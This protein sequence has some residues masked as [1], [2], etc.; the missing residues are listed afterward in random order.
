MDISAPSYF[1][2]HKGTMLTHS[3]LVALAT[4]LLAL[5]SLSLS[6][7]AHH[8]TPLWFP[9]AAAI[10]VLYR[11]PPRHWGLPLLASGLGIVLASFALIGISILPVKL[12]AINLLEAAVCAQLLRRSLPASDPLSDLSSWL[13]FVVCAVI[14]TPLF[15]ALLA[16]VA[17]PA[18]DQPFWQP[19]GTWFISEAIGVLSLAPLGLSYRRRT[20]AT[21]NLY[22]LLLTLMLTL[23]FSYLA[24]I[25]LPFPFTFVILPLLWAAIALPRFE[26]FTVCFC[27]ILLITVM[28]SLGLAHFQTANSRLGDLGLYLPMLLILVPAHAMAM[29]MHTFRVEKQH[30]VESESR[31]RSALEYSAIGMALVS[32]EGKWLQVNQA[33]CKLL[34]YTPERL[35]RLTFQAITHPDDLNADLSQ[36]HDLLD[37][38]ISSYTME[39]RYI[40]SDGQTVWALL[41]VSLVRDAEGQPLYFI[42]QVED[43]SGLKRSE[44]ENNRLVERITLANQVGGVG[45]WEWV[46]NQENF[47]WDQRMFELYD[48]SPDQAPTLA[49][50]RTLLVPEDRDRTDR[51]LAEILAQPRPFVMEFRIITRSGKL[52]HIRGQGNVILDDQGRPLRLIGTNIDMTELKSLAEALHEEKERLHITL[53]AIGEGVISTDS[54]QRIT[55]MNPVAE[56]MCGWPLDLAIGMPVAGVVR[57][58][59]GKDGPEIENLTQYPRQWPADYALVLHSRD[60]RYFDV[61][62]SV[63]PLKT[64]DGETMG[65]VMVLQDVTASREL[66]KKLSYSASHDALTGL[67]N[68]T[69]FEK[70]LKAAIVAGGEPSPHSLVFLDLDR[71]KAVNDTAGH[72]AGDAL[73]RD[74][75]QLMRHQ[76]RGSD[77]LARL[78]GDEFGLILFD[79]RL[80]QAKSLMQQ[81]VNQISQHPFYWEG[82]IYRVGASAG[83]TRIDGDAKSSE[84]LAQADIACYTAKH[85]GRGQVYLYETRQKQLLE[86]QHE[87][88]N[89]QEVQAIVSE[90]QLR[91]L[92]RAVAPPATPLSAAFHQVKLQVMAPDDRPL[93]HEAFIA[94]AQLYGLMPDIDRWTVAQLL[95]KHADDIKRKGLSLALPL[96]TDSLLSADFQHYLTDTVRASSLPPQALLF[97]V[98]EAVVLEHA[99]QCRAFLRGLQ[100]LGCRLIV[101]GF[102]HNIN[103]FDELNDQK[104]DII[105]I[106]ERFIT[107]V[108][109]NQMDELMVSMLNGAAHRIK[110]QTLAGPAHQPVTLQALRDVGVDLADGDLVALE[111]PLT[112][113]LSDG[114][115]GIR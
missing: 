14:F 3:L 89:P 75:A 113:L 115:F 78:G 71:F 6:S 73:L 112:V 57:L 61:Q 15:S 99:A 100:Q 24:L 16:T 87:L 62:Q 72:A 60:G 101:N 67:P 50:W 25:Y 92:T 111:Q 9:T 102:G 41:A 53:D 81:V 11:H 90:G 86:R 36:L 13:R 58:T 44:A 88:L 28:I 94:A 32:P 95:V 70:Q 106:D 76:L 56:Q 48:L 31:F 8:F 84:L 59:N 63:S 74:I 98:D 5:L 18:P 26:A 110:A 29:V 83:I 80:E 51:E 23:V 65:A 85:H 97:S 22:P 37:G 68:R 12:A 52:R 27:T 82:K 10:A 38:H 96:A 43:I 20:L 108:H 33:L 46:M 107:N 42:S 30:I 40:R 54:H 7:E 104:I 91:L 66:M 45:I 103:A 77:C 17:A 93:P 35:H 69:R 105:R 39:K 114:Y 21:L 2:T 47:T 19:F 55:F 64:L 79:C 109:C 1:G 34:G 4:F 49:L